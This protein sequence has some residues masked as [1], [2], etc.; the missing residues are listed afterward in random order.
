MSLKMSGHTENERGASDGRIRM[1]WWERFWRNVVAS[2]AFPVIV[3]A[4]WPRFVRWALAWS[5]VAIIAMSWAAWR[6]R[7][8]ENGR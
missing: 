4:L 1:F 8:R 5:A 3:Y 7:N 2:A 6:R